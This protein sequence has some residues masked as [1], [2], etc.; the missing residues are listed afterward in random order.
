MLR[1]QSRNV[2]HSFG[3]TTAGFV[4]C[5][6]DTCNQSPSSESTCN[7]PSLLFRC[8]RVLGRHNNNRTRRARHRVARGGCNS[9]VAGRLSATPHHFGRF[10]P[11]PTAAVAA[12][13]RSRRRRLRFRLRPRAGAP[14]GA[15]RLAGARAGAAG[16]AAAGAPSDRLGL[17]LSNLLSIGGSSR[18]GGRSR[19]RRRRALLTLR[20]GAAARR[21]GPRAA[22]DGSRAWQTV[23]DVRQRRAAK[24]NAASPARWAGG[25]AP[26]W[27]AAFQ[28]RKY[29]PEP[30][31][32]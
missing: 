32:P 20:G 13:S 11:P 24:K 4:R 25:R 15:T 22:G 14:A 30:R 18:P 19:A 23:G 31:Q 21:R 27:G 2:W 6:P 9:R 5:L 28:T 3:L 17:L 8:A 1:A 29:N 16:G 10:P 7:K 26:F 12:G